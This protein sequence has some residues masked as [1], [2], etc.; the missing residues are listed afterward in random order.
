[1]RWYSETEP[2]CCFVAITLTYGPPSRQKTRKSRTVGPYASKPGPEGPNAKNRPATSAQP[3]KKAK[4]RLTNSDWM[5]AYKWIDKHP[6]ETQADTAKYFAT[7]PGG[8]LM[9]TLVEMMDAATKLMRH[10]QS[11]V[12]ALSCQISA[13]SSELNSRGYNG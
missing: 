11:A 13:A 9:I 7:R 1:M 6:Y 3:S 12:L 5:D 2:T 10:F 8:A 4:V